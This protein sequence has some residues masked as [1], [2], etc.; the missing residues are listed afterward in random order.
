MK[1][2]FWIGLFLAGLLVA[3]GAASLQSVP[4]YMDADYYYSGALRLA[5]GQGGSEPYLWNYLNDPAAL[6][7][8]AFS[9]WMPGVS[10]LA[11]AGLAL[12]GGAGFWGARLG[13]L[14]LAACVPL[15]TARLALRL[16]G[17]TAHAR[18]AGLLAL[19]PGFYLAYQTTT[20][21]FSIYMVLGSAFLLLAYTEQG[22]FARL[23]DAARLFGLGLLSGLLHMTRADGLL[24]L[25]AAA[26]VALHFVLTNHRRAGGGV[27]WKAVPYAAACAAAVLA[28]YAL[29]T[30]PWYLRNLREWG[31]LMPPGGSRALWITTYEETMLFPAS[32]LTPQHWL[33]AGWG[34]HFQAWGKALLANLQS[35]VAVQG[36]ILLFPFILVGA[37]RLR[38]CPE[39]RLGGGMWL[40]TAAVMTFAFPYAGLNGGF[41][42]SGAALQPFLWALAPLGI[43]TV[44]LW[45]ARKRRLG[46]PQGMVRFMFGLVVVVA[47]LLSGLLYVQR[48]VGSQ[49]GVF[50]WR[51]SDRHY[52]EVEQVLLQQG[53]REGDAVL[54]NNPPGYHLTSGRAAV[55]IP[56]GD[57]QMLLAA[58]EKYGIRY[59]VLEITNPEQLADLYYGR[60]SPPE[61]EYLTAVGKTR[62][63]RIHPSG[64]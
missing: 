49:P 36:S 40:L 13:F 43:E 1:T 7:S 54:V 26:W 44:M 12:T 28:G 47:F 45:Y 59:L 18:L 51:A 3:F 4:G 11:A 63:Y 19:F 42:H 37:W 5:A 41:F 27:L 48:V 57:E 55:V 30:A 34:S 21:A 17:Q 2:R 38:V 9:Y 10:L 50:Q 35:V 53:A 23:P 62:L 39:V 14:L 24:W 29:I 15:L 16:N 60:V 6:P 46:W 22:L 31:S 52:R 61:L 20:D 33:S 56:Y 64:D 58:A 25:A 8:P 32:L